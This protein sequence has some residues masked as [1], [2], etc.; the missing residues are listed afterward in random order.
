MIYIDYNVIKYLKNILVLGNKFLICI[1]IT[2]KPKYLFMFN[3]LVL[4]YLFLFKIKYGKDNEY[5]II[6]V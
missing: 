2:F 1:F 5:K 3:I 6:S 4:K